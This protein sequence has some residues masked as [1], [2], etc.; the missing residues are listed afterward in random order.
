MTVLLWKGCR[1]TLGQL[2]GDLEDAKRAGLTNVI[3][4]PVSAHSRTA[5]VNALA[6]LMADGIIDNE[7]MA[8]PPGYGIHARISKAVV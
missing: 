4:K 5:I 1:R 3:G 2:Q 8:R 7:P 6:G